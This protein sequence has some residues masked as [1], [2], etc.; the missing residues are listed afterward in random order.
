MNILIVDDKEENRYLLEALLKGN[1][2]DVESVSNGAEALEKLKSGGFELIISD[3]LMPVMDG[4]KLCRKVKTDKT[5]S[6]IPFLIYTATNTGP[7]DEEFAFRI[8]AD[9]FIVKP[10]E[11][12]VFMEIVHDVMA[13]AKQNN[14]KSPLEPSQEEEVLKLYNE[15]LVR[16]LEQKM[17]QLEK[18]VQERRETEEILRESEEKYKSIL[19]NIEDGYYEVDLSGNFVF[20]NNSM[21][22]MLGYTRSELLGMNNRAYMDKENA[23]KVFQ[24]FNRVFTTG[25]SSRELDW[26]LITKQGTKCHID[27]SASLIRDGDGNAIGFRGIARDVSERRTAEKEK[28]L[29]TEQLQQ[30]QKLESVGRLAGG[31][32]HDFNNLLSIILGYGEIVLESLGRDH[33]HREPLEQIYQA[34][35]RAKALTR[36]LLAFSRKQVLETKV[37]DIKT[38]VTGFEKLLSRLIGEDIQLNLSLTSNPLIV[39]A[40]IS[41]LEQVL[42]N[43]AVNARDAM[44]DGGT[45]TI[46]TAIVE[47]DETYSEIKPGIP[48]GS[49][50]MIGVSDSGCGMD[51][52]TRK[53][54][55][56]PFFTTKGDEKGTGLGLA[57]SYG[58]IKQH[59]GDIWAYS[60]PNQGTIF[61]VYLPLCDEVAA[62][63][64]TVSVPVNLLGN[65]TIL[66]VEDNEMV[67]NLSKTILQNQGYT[68]L[69][70]ENG[71]DAFAV[72]ENHDGPLDLLLTDVIMPGIN[73]RDLFEKIAGRYPNVKVLFMSGY[74]DD[75][76][77]HRGMI[78]D[79][80]AFIQKPFSVKGLAAKVRETIDKE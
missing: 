20:F 35:I 10:C 7:K 55:F 45:L 77:T 47:I 70:A 49:Y 66:V 43:L 37:C 14:I 27:T 68:V 53:R 71:N 54:I 34:G 67:R 64:E 46:E 9:R 41:Q 61:K 59:G 13:A 58:I 4:F 79:G 21:C 25:E 5:L 42:M 76:I 28:A 73:G 36:Q 78:D 56:E 40:D 19:D 26:T 52:E 63:S 2:H 3:I 44:P 18:E 69:S 51:K 23:K 72:L 24:T 11:P 1:G 17:L 30:A 50:A 60:E 6:H 8:G 39:K 31:V 15:R 16:K 29:L 38:V 22:K 57:T 80:V 65:E 62:S 75:V 74:A 32:A 33:P 48:T 12:D